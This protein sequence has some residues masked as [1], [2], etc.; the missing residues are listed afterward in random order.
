MTIAENVMAVR[1]KIIDAA[2]AAGRDPKDIL[3][4]AATKMNSADRVKEAVAAGI[5]ACGENRVQE[6]Q[7][8]LPLGAYE[9]KPLHFIGHLQRNKV[10]NVVG[11]CDLIQS[12]DSLELIDMISSRAQNM[13]IVQKI[14]IEI[15][16][17]G[18]DAKSGIAPAELERVLEYVAG[19]PAI[20]VRGLMAIPPISQ[21]SGANK[22]YF[23]AMYNLFI[24]TSAK[25]YDNVSM[26]LLSMGM[27]DDYTDA[28]ACG[29]NMVRVGS[30]I[31]GARHYN[32]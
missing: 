10:K 7:E 8:K 21:F 14:L 31:F 1:Q 23:D 18:E 19:K 6:I 22:Q 27:S 2:K 17:G 9:G 4:V 15:N 12:V 25:K 20:D 13:G 5:D 30:A 28:I 32:K 26:Q 16:I 24:D 29:A 11:T 3:L